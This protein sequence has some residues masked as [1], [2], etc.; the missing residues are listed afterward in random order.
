MGRKNEFT[1]FLMDSV[2]RGPK[3]PSHLDG[4]Q[5]KTA[6]YNISA[7]FCTLG[8]RM[9]DTQRPLSWRAIVLDSTGRQQSLRLDHNKRTNQACRYWSLVFDPIQYNFAQYAVGKGYFVFFFDRL[10][11]GT[12]TR[13]V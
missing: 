2:E 1:Q 13:Y 10:G 4:P 12:S 6:Q 11:V 5:N 9:L 3:G 7:T 8:I